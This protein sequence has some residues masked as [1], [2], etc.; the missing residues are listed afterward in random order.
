MVVKLDP[1]L[2]LNYNEHKAHLDGK[3]IL[4]Y[5][6]RPKEN[7]IEYEGVKYSIGPSESI[8]ISGSISNPKRAVYKI[9]SSYDSH[10]VLSSADS[11][12]F[13][14]VYDGFET[15]SFSTGGAADA[16]KQLKFLFY[17]LELE[18]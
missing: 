5:D 13:M 15:S 6:R 16:P 17:P 7:L 1:K 9:T 4:Y 11:H 12:G 14:F 18:K 2:F 8:K 3:I 10:L